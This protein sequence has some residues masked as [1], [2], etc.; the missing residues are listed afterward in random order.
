MLES[1]HALSFFSGRSYYSGAYELS[2]TS[3]QWSEPREWKSK[4]TSRPRVSAQTHFLAASV[5]WTTENVV[6]LQPVGPI[7]TVYNYDEFGGMWHLQT[8]DFSLRLAYCA[9]RLALI[10]LRLA[11]LRLVFNNGKDSTIYSL[12]LQS[13]NVRHRKFTEFSD[14]PWRVRNATYRCITREFQASRF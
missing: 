12:C 2:S 9:L 14:P 6:S 4:E 13:T 8:T 1:L 11:C 5:H 3:R 10:A 7:Y